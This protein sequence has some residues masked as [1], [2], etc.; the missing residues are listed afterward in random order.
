VPDFFKQVGA[1][2]F[3]VMAGVA[4]ALTAFFLYVAGVVTEPPKTILFS[5]L[6]SREAAA[7]TAKL[8]GMAVKYD[9]KDGGT[10]LVPAD[11]VTKLRM[12]LAQDNLP[13][14]GIGYEIFDK[15]DAFGTT[16]FVQ[17]INQ[18]RALEGE[19]SRS[20][21][22]IEGIQSARV[23]LV[24]PERQ[25]FSREEQNPSASVV[26]KTR[27]KLDRGQVGA[28]QHLVAAAVQG[29]SAQRVAIVDDGGT[30]LAGGD[31]GSGG[32]ATSADQDQQTS[33]YEERLRTRI[34]SLVG[35]VV[36]V[37]H[38]RAQV[39]ADM[40]FAHTSETKEHFDPDSKVL[41]S[42]QTVERNATD[43][44]G[45]SQAMSVANQLPGGGGQA[46]GAGDGIKSSS[47]STE[48]TSN[49]EIDKTV[50][51]STNDSGSLKRLSVAVV[52]DGD[53]AKARSAAEMAQIEALVK[54]S[55][56]F[57]PARGDQ[58]QVKNM[59]FA[60]LDAG[61][62]G[63]VEKPLLGLDSAYWFKIIEAGIFCLTALLIALF[64]ARPLIKR[65]FAAQ[66]GGVASYAPD[67]TPLAA[68]GS[69]VV[70]A[71]PAPG[72]P[73]AAAG[74]HAALP[75]PGGS[76]VTVIRNGTVVEQ[77]GPLVAMK[78][79]GIDL[80]QLE[81]GFGENSVKKVGEVVSAHP[82]EALSIIRT[83]LHQPA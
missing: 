39:T 31:G 49:Y 32:A 18:L 29:L 11:Q 68:N 60:K 44:N 40:A 62:A 3:G 13:A 56:G 19:L 77:D 25:I 41:R 16:A 81:G 76:G 34:E 65:M 47:G 73:A 59:A 78:Q 15:S 21:Q 24:I 42:N 1:A 83:W 28:I 9:V 53:G 6:E 35:S 74:G 37:G 55:M 64:V 50:T 75:A 80:S 8:D 10:I 66:N 58:L 26:L 30:L 45:G 48:E 51:T 2:R 71:L 4:A 22:T 27:S 17:N 63:P 79:G 52:V 46:G 72:S 38:V 5:G 82:E 67:G 36:G 23:H 70:G 20:I 33:D 12:S 43:A 61:D 54:S 57:D 14:A 7:V 69:P